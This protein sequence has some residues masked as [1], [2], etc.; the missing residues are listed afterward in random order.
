MFTSETPLIPKRYNYYGL[1]KVRLLYV[2]K[3]NKEIK[4]NRPA[5]FSKRTRSSSL[6][7][8]SQESDVISTN[9]TLHMSGEKQIKGQQMM[10]AHIIMLFIKYFF[11]IDFQDK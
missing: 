4:Y 1:D 7:S 9:I 3:K 2:K 8:I 6:P 11:S 5:G 10:N